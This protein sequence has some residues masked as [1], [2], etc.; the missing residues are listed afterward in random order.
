MGRRVHT[1]HS[2]S[3]QEMVWRVTATSQSASSLW[4]S[5]PSR[6]RP[7]GPEPPAQVRRQLRRRP[8]RV[9]ACSGVQPLQEDE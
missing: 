9:M 5:L 8:G 4:E 7:E 3:A 6:A 1:R 2:G